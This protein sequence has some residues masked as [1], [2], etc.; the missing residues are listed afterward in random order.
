MSESH[1][2]DG[3]N[4]GYADQLYER[5]LRDRGIVP[6]SLIDA[7]LNGYP[8]PSVVPDDTAAARAR[9]VAAGPADAD[10]TRHM[11][12][13]ATAAGALAEDFRTYGHLLVPLDP[14]GSE[15]PG[16]PSLTLEFHDVT[17]DDLSRV[18][19]AA[20][21]LERLGETALDV[22]ESLRRIYC[23]RIGYELEHMDDVEQWNWLVEYIESGRHLEPPSRETKLR[24]LEVLTEVEG[25][26]RFLHRAFL[27]QKRFSIEGL[28]M[29][30]P[31]LG[32][33]ARIAAEAGTKQVFLGMAHRGRLAVLSR[34][35]GR[36]YE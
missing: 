12:H 2:A 11:L 35:V 17:E 21:G 6:P 36:P 31:M 7:D 32:R 33:A 1:Q 16:H 13:T 14:L 25:F 27:G 28:D 4:A 24:V 10:V 3:Y 30:I 23:G 5:R 29:M 8:A 26:E 20:I 22:V 9:V 19:A 34:L 18:P 15:P